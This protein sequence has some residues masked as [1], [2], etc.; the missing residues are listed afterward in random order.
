MWVQHC[1]H[2]VQGVTHL[3]SNPLSEG[4]LSSCAMDL[5]AVPVE[6]VMSLFVDLCSRACRVDLCQ[7]QPQAPFCRNVAAHLALMGGT[8]RWD[9]RRHSPA[10]N[11]YNLSPGRR[12]FGEY[13]GRARA[14]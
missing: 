1:R 12:I 11:A 10:C 6:A 13:R 3:I 9:G 5:G 7:L 8:V 4:S 14:Q 2:S